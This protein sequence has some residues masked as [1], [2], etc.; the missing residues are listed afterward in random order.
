MAHQAA[1]LM[2][3]LFK[4]FSASA[5]ILVTVIAASHVSA[6]PENLRA[7][8]VC[9]SVVGIAP[10]SVDLPIEAGQSARITGCNFGASQGEVEVCSSSAHS[11]ATC[12][13][14]T[15]TSWSS[16]EITVTINGGSF[17]NGQQVWVYVRDSTTAVNAFGLGPL[18]ITVAATCTTTLN[19]GGDVN[20]AITNATGGDT[21]CL[22][23]GTYAITVTSVTKSPRVTVKS[24]SGIS[25]TVTLLDLTSVNGLTFTS[26]TVTDVNIDGN[27]TNNLTLSRITQ[28]P[29]TGSYWEIDC[30]NWTAMAR[31]IVLDGNTHEDAYDQD[32][33]PQ[34]GQ[35]GRLSFVGGSNGSGTEA[36]NCGG[37][38]VKNSLFKGSLAPQRCSDGIFLQAGNIHIG[39]N[40]IFTEIYDTGTDC[41]THVDAIQCYDCEDGI[42]IDGNYFHDNKVIFGW[43]D[44]FD[45]DGNEGFQITNNIFANCSGDGVPYD[46]YLGGLRRVTLAHNTFFNC[47]LNAGHKVGDPENTEWV[48]ENNIFDNASLNQQESPG[49]GSDCTNRYNLRSNGGSTYLTCSPGCVTGTADYIGV[50]SIANWSN[51]QLDT[52]SPGKNAGNDGLDMGTLCYG[53]C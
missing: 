11:G 7:T 53:S 9:S 49:C 52:G 24:T 5:A 18:P 45:G 46:S 30:G 47:D 44:S 34:G 21:I 31:S 13:D 29:L 12:V 41:T 2:R 37:L 35:E 48:V 1:R 15:V 33:D 43:Y 36:A 19:S 20:T 50:G 6:Q 32:T 22:N 25:A 42:V 39:P 40:N 3:S 23:T 14:A 4:S 16:T 51:W 28:S 8:F 38:Q 10:L 17:T 27:G 26:L